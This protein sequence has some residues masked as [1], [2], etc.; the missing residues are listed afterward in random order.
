[1]D[2]EPSA[3]TAKTVFVIDM[4]PRVYRTLAASSRLHSAAASRDTTQNWTAIRPNRNTPHTQNT[5]PATAGIPIT[6]T[7]FHSTRDGSPYD[8]ATTSVVA[9]THASA[10]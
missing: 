2:H 6:N 4:S 5:T 8:R 7:V 9:I 3:N 1:M 10:H